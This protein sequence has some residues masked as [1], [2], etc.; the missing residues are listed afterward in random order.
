MTAQIQAAMRLLPSQREI[1]DWFS[2]IPTEEL[3]L[4]VDESH[5]DEASALVNN[6]PWDFY[7]LSD[8]S[9]VTESSFSREAATRFT[10][11]TLKS[12]LAAHPWVVVGDSFILQVVR[13]MGFK[14]FGEFIDERYDTVSDPDHRFLLVCEQIALLNRELSSNEGYLN[15]LAEICR[16]NQ[17]LLLSER[18]RQKLLNDY[19]ASLA[20]A[21]QR[22]H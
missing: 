16:F 22:C 8:F 2:E 15:P 6:T 17:E 19:H 18:F 10:E 12:I 13:N 4:S 21:L 7:A 5:S 1:L 9:I 11:K 20:R 14:T 3:F